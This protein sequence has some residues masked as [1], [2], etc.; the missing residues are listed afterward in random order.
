MAPTRDYKWA[1]SRL[2][3]YLDALERYE[4]LP[5]DEHGDRT[6]RGD[7]YAWLE[8][9]QDTI[10]AIASEL[11]PDTVWSLVGTGPWSAWLYEQQSHVRRC[12][13]VLQQ[14]AELAEKWSKQ[15]TIELDL[16][17]LH[18]W[19]WNAAIDFWD[20]GHWGEA[21]EAAIK[22]V[23]AKLQERVERRDLSG[24]SLVR[25]AFSANPPTSGGQRLRVAPDDDS[26]TYQS[27]QEGAMH[28]G[29][30]VF[31]YW[32]NVLAHEPGGAT[33]QAAVEALGAVS[34]F[35]RLVDTSPMDMSEQ[36]AD[37]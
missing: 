14:E 2:Q 6:Q 29:E 17:S 22:V 21:V 31:M 25:D 15:P 5:R 7:A 3:E 37:T 24:T 8:A 30:A 1:E 9:N 20:S 4:A 18:P 11:V 36:D 23:N 34:T 19:V 10:S 16:E 27:A 13:G 35:A 26:D 33:K 28:L 32:R 12:L